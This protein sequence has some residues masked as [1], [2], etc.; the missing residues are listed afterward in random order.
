MD[1]T[2]SIHEQVPIFKEEWYYVRP[3]DSI[4]L[5]TVKGKSKKAE[6]QALLVKKEMS[7]HIL[8]NMVKMS[9]QG[10]LSLT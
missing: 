8:Q 7:L 3:N 5:F 10:I 6:S 4:F 9:L 1:R 2:D